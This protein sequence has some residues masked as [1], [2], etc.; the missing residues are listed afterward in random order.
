VPYRKEGAVP[1]T[2]ITNYQREG[3]Y[4]LIRN[5]LGSIGDVWTAL[6][7]T[8]DFET[9][10][11]LGIEFGEDFRLLQDLGWHPNDSR[12]TVALTMPTDDLAELL[13][14]LQDEAERV[15]T[16]SRTE[17]ESAAL[18]AEVDARF[19]V[20]YEACEKLLADLDPREGEQA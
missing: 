16:E 17:R 18:D 11:R 13:K 2:T 4:E 12:Q 10:E 9:A 1:T 15:L 7:E 3:L 6:E 8:E 14:R 19:Q 5:H 20:G